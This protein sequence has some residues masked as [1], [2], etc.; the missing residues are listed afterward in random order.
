[1]EKQEFS[2]QAQSPDRDA[3]QAAERSFRREI[4][5]W[6]ECFVTPF[7][8]VIFIFIFVCRTNLVDGTSMLPTLEDG[9]RMLV[10]N[11][12]FTPEQGDIIIF[13]K[14]SFKEEPL[15]KRVIAVA[16][17]TVDI[18][19]VA[20]TVSVDDVVLEEDYISEPTSLMYDVTFPVTVPEG[21]VFVMGDNR[22]DSA[23]S[24]YGPIG[25]VDTRY[26]IGKV[27]AVITPFSRFGGLE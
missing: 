12:L 17:Q 3:E 24:R 26:I 16:G 23:D 8:F 9:D 13:R 27:Y 20:G 11:L 19:P 14:A 10:S 15:V 21:C 4:Y 1:M 5:D 7:V 2:A 6:V 22:N 18:D 25:M